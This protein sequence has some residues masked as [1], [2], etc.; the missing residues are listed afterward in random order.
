MRDFHF[1]HISPVPPTP[2]DLAPPAKP[3]SRIPGVQQRSG[4]MAHRLRKDTGPSG[5]HGQPGGVIQERN[6]W[7]VAIFTICINLIKFLITSSGFYGTI[8]RVVSLYCCKI[9]TTCIQRDHLTLGRSKPP[10]LFV[11]K[12]YGENI[13][14][15]YDHILFVNTIKCGICSGNMKAIYFPAT[16]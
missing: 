7:D 10:V 1:T 5:N 14:H 2:P 15:P 8:K 6:L 11:G 16:P 3:L 9:S 12:F 4:G 13:M